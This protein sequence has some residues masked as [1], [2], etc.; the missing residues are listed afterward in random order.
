[1]P[2]A[3]RILERLPS[4]YRPEPDYDRGDLLLS[5]ASAVGGVLDALSS[6]SAEVMQAHWFGYADSAIYSAWLGRA[7]SLAGAGPLTLS[8]PAIEQ[9]PHLDDLPRIAGLVDVRPWRE[10]LRDRERVETFRTRVRRLV[11]LHKDGLGT[12]RALRTMT[13]AALPEVDPDAPE[14]LRERSFTV[15]EFSAVRGELLPIAQPGLPASLVGPLMRWKVDSGSLYAVPPVIVIEGVAPVE[16]EIDATSEPIIERFDPASGTGIGI[17]YR[18]DL[19]PGQALAIVSGFESWLGRGAGIDRAEIVPDGLEACDPTAP[20]P[21]SAAPGAP[22]GAVVALAQTADQFL[23]AAV[24]DA[25]V[26]ALWR[27]DGA[28]WQQVLGGLP[29]LHCLLARGNELLFGSANGLARLPIQPDG[30]FVATPD[31]A[32]ATD[33]AV[34]ALA[35]DST[36]TVWAATARGLA[37]EHTGALAYT[38]LGNRAETE[39]TLRCVLPQASGDVY[40]GG[41]LGLLLYRPSRARWYLLASEFVDETVDDWVELDL[42]SGGLPAAA[43]VFVPPVHSLARGGDGDIWLGTARGIGR[44]RAREQRRTYTTLLD[45]RPDLTTAVVH[46]IEVD[47]RERLWFAT[48]EGLFVYDG[49]DWFQRQGAAL[50]RLPRT[51]EGDLPVFWRF[52]RS[53]D[54]WQSLTPPARAGFVSFAG[55]Q[56]GAA[57]QPVLAIAWTETARALLGAFDGA[58]FTVDDAAVPASLGARYKPTLTRIVDGGIA[59]V[60]RLSTGVS[61][62]RYLRREEDTPPAP[63]ANPAWTREGRLLPPPDA[64]AAPYEGRYLAEE[65]APGDSVF[66]FAPAARVWLI[67]EPRAPLAVTVRLTRAAPDESIDPSI[68]DRVWSELQRVKPAGVSVYLAVDDYIVRGL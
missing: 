30:A 27:S 53:I 22:S 39:T 65:L 68:L 34:F 10:P 66:A 1:M 36:G 24:N 48:A 15:E 20:G 56:L 61:H 19:A 63:S 31:L 29:V 38:E 14:G 16:G 3:P 11:R 9:F 8:D 62:W 58:T 55:T 33:P 21:W 43:D 60:P 45:A 25:E 28:T 26:G 67:W 46:A 40:C 57:E 44:Y 47:A 50:V 4:L 59:A 51:E 52:D 37:R 18:G 6:A 17:H 12:V 13:M 49:L 23:W 42:V 64:A 7:R 54:R 2:S 35:A 41:E 5:F 32:V